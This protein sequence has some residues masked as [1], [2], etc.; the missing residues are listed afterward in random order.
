MTVT[1]YSELRD[2]AVEAE[3]T[4]GRLARRSLKIKDREIEAH[5]FLISQITQLIE[6]YH[7]SI[8]VK[9]CCF[10]D[11]DLVVASVLSHC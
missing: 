1:L 11:L 9:E 4:D 10:I 2:L 7:A 5:Q 8:E 3:Q 6:D